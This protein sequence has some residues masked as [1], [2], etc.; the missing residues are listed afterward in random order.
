MASA[1][2]RSMRARRVALGYGADHGLPVDHEGRR[3]VDAEARAESHVR[4]H[5]TRGLRCDDARLPGSHI[6][7]RHLLRVGEERGVIERCREQKVVHRPELALFASALRGDA[8]GLRV[9][10]DAREREVLEHDAQVRAVDGLDVGQDGLF[11]P[12]ERALEVRELDDGHPGIA[13][14]ALGRVA[15]RH[16]E[17]R[18]DRAGLPAGDQRREKPCNG[19]LPDG[20]GTDRV[21]AVPAGGPS[22]RSSRAGPRA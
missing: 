11:E 21:T 10:V 2:A 7:A 16:L 4:G 14:A 22:S 3:R 18:S 8:G 5:T 17:S 13:R 9:W 6:E 1:R 12:A 20:R 15:D 19:C